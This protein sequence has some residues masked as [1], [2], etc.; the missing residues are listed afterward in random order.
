MYVCIYSLY[1]QTVHVFVHF[2]QANTALS[3][4]PKVISVSELEG[5]T[6]PSAPPTATPTPGSLPPDL[7]ALMNP[8]PHGGP[9]RPPTFQPVA[10]TLEYFRTP[11][12][13]QMVPGGVCVCVC[14]H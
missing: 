11:F 8:P 1:V 3:S 14:V 13:I 6:S 5:G 10:M 7:A 9:G 2:F 4:S 12:P